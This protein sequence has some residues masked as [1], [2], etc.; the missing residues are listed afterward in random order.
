[1]TALII[2]A[3]AIAALNARVG[4]LLLAANPDRTPTTSDRS[5]S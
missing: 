4:F 2:T 3:L 1:M 5:K